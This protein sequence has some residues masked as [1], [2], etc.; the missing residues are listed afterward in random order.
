MKSA[1]P[2]KGVYKIPIHKHTP[3]RMAMSKWKIRL[4][5]YSWIDGLRCPKHKNVIDIS[6]VPKKKRI[7]AFTEKEFME[8]YNY[9][10]IFKSTKK[11]SLWQQIKRKVKR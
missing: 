11:P 4:D 10:T 7:P 8:I 9:Y 3:V 1:R 2:H 5:G 6:R